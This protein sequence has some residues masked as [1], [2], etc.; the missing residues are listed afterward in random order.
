[1]CGLY[2]DSILLR[3][4]YMGEISLDIYGKN[5]ENIFPKLNTSKYDD[6]EV[7]VVCRRP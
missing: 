5:I 7:E 2:K 3:Y 4:N 1:M 6:H